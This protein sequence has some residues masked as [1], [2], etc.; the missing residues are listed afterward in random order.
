M[1]IIIS[2]LD[3]QLRLEIGALSILEERESR[4][5]SILGLWGFLGSTILC[6]DTIFPKQIDK[7]G[8]LKV[9]SS[10]AFCA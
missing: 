10:E 8:L 5:I 9:S 6:I 2:V 7:Q 4:M 3:L 1:I